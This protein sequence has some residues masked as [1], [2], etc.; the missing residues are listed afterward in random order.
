MPRPFSQFRDEDQRAAD[1]RRAQ[2]LERQLAGEIS[3][4]ATT[5]V[6]HS[7]AARI[8][9]VPLTGLARAARSGLGFSPV[10]DAFTSAGGIDGA[11]PLA[12]PE[13]D[14]RMVPDLD[15]LAVLPAP[16]GWAWAPGDRFHQDGTVYAG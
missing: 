16:E 13:G 12:S 5:F 4:V 9:A 3:G 15:Q 14:L 2:V 6:D 8:K 1:E 10:L 11:S 7:G